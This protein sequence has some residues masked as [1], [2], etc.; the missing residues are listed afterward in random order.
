MRRRRPSGR[1][2]VASRVTARPEELGAEVAGRRPEQGH[3]RTG[4][5]VHLLEHGLRAGPY[6][7]LP[8]YDVHVSVLADVPLQPRLAAG[9]QAGA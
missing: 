5:P 6:D 3:P 8:D 2:Q 1:G 9:I 4:W 7:E